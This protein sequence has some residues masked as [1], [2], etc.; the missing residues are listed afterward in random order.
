MRAGADCIC[1]VGAVTL[2]DDPKGAAEQMVEAI[3]AA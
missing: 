1:A 2:A 3:E